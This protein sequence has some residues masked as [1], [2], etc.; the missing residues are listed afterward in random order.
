MLYKTKNSKKYRLII[1]WDIPHLPLQTHSWPFSIL[2]CALGG[3]P[4]GAV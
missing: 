3:W 2:V 1:F 4:S